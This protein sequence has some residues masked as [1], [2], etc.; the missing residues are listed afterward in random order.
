MPSDLVV[1]RFLTAQDAVHKELEMK[2]TK[3]ELEETRRRVSAD[4]T[5]AENKV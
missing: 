1:T 2:R 5:S 3:R 4:L